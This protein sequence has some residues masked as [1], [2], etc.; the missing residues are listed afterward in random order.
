MFYNGIFI[1]SMNN[2]TLVFIIVKQIFSLLVL[3]YLKNLCKYRFYIIVLC[4]RR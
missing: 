4:N 2:Y 1:C 3:L